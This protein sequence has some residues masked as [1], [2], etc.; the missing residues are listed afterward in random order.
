MVWH[1]IVKQLI[2]VR[3]VTHKTRASFSLVPTQIDSPQFSHYVIV[4]GTRFFF[5]NYLAGVP[6]D[7]SR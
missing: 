3:F 1:M 7:L 4:P 6:K 5:S 2:L